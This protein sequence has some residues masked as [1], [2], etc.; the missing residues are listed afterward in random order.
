[1]ATDK[2]VISKSKFEVS[3]HL[4][5][6]TLALES[7]N[8][9]IKSRNE[10]GKS[11]REVTNLLFPN[12]DPVEAI[13]GELKKLTHIDYVEV[14]EHYLDKKKELW[15]FGKKY[16]EGDVYIKFCITLFKRELCGNHE[17]FVFSF[18]WAKWKLT[19]D[20]FPYR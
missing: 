6:L 10:D 4:K 9:V 17:T 8:I 5:K 14:I 13:K 18:H 19:D 15:V 7:G 20:M 11:Y 12:S 16:A 1:M 3:C 2:I